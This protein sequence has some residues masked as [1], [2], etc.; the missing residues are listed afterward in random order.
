MTSGGPRTVLREEDGELLAML[1]WQFPRPRLVVSSAS[2]GG[3]LG[4]RGWVLNAQVASA[5]ARTDLDEHVAELANL[6]EL[7]GPGVGMLTA[8]DV[9]SRW[10]AA[11]GGVRVTATV[12]L[13]HPVWAAT[14]SADGRCDV[15]GRMPVGTVNVVAE[16]PVRLDDGALVNAVVTV[17][18]AKC[19]A[20]RDAGVPGT[21][22]PSD[23][24]TVVCPAD[25]RPQRFGG[26]RSEWGA[27]LARATH[28]AILDGALPG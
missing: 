25:G 4:T 6:A 27:R 15:T 17:T 3:G 8:V 19:Q 22:T 20:L 28:R 7:A 21:G 10:R 23:G 13:T 18:E 1:V 9:R 2:S 16:L 24:V 14:G 11:A 26:P 12:G 5:Y